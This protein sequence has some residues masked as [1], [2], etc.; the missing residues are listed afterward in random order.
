MSVPGAEYPRAAAVPGAYAASKC[1]GRAKQLYDIVKNPLPP[2]AHMR[3]GAQ[4]F[5]SKICG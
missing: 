4:V 1:C 3:I 2:Y 5:N